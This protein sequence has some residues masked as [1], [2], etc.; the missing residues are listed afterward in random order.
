VNV[1]A[2]V[3]C[4]DVAYRPQ[5]DLAAD[6]QATATTCAVATAV[7]TAAPDR[8]NS[9]LPYSSGGF[10]CVAGPGTQPLGGGMPWREY[11]CTDAHAS[12]ITF[13]RY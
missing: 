4:A 8:P 3:T 13:K 12:V 2:T 10:A 11:R 6:I 5:S 1:P 9:G 7:V